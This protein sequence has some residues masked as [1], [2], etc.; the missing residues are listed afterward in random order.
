ME[1]RQ[2][3]YF[4]AVA[5]EGTYVAAAA[6]LSVAQ[7]ALW[8]Q[9][10]DLERT[11]GVPLFER[12]GRRVRLTADGQ[13]LLEQITSALATI[14]RVDATASDLRSSRT[15]VVAIACASPHLRRFLAPVIGSFRRSH[16]GVAIKVREYGGGS[17]PGRGIP[18]DLLDGLVDLATGVT[19]TDDPRFDGLPI[20]EVRLVLAVPDDHPWRDAPSIEVARLRDLPLVLSQRG[21]YS[22]RALEAACLRAGF[23]PVVAFDSASPTSVVALGEAMLGVPITIDDALPIPTTR[24]WP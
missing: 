6:A 17:A 12:V 16:P 9:V 13:I 21:A 10:R 23:E 24:P 15:G 22:R 2:L 8:R 18:N 14:D 20:Y 3:R 5:R 7:P 19:P 11:L 4:V 1:L